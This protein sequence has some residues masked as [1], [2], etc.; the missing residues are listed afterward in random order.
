MQC[1]FYKDF[2]HQH[3]INVL[4]FVYS[5]ITRHFFH[6]HYQDADEF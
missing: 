3:A 6:D 1:Y 2:T 5:V 4:L